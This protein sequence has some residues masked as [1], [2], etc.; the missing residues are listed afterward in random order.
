MQL[1]LPVLTTVG[2]TATLHGQLFVEEFSDPVQ[3]THVALQR[4][5]IK[6]C[7]DFLKVIF[8]FHL[9]MRFQHHLLHF[10]SR[11]GIEM[12]GLQMHFEVG[13]NAVQIGGDN[14]ILRSLRL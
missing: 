13:E 6:S 4:L 14:T 5:L 12:H 10:F 1:L 9:K 7:A 2:G 11:I 8:I 3:S